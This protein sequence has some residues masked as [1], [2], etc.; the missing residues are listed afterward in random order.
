MCLDG[1]SSTPCLLKRADAHLCKNWDRWTL[2]SPLCNI[3]L[4]KWVEFRTINIKLA[5]GR[6]RKGLVTVTY[7]KC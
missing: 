6:F 1:Y 7:C 5:R 4:L 3:F 2:N